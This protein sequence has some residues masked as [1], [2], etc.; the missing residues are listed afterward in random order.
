[1]PVVRPSL[2]DPKRLLCRG[3]VLGFVRLRPRP[4]QH[5]QRRSLRQAAGPRRRAAVELEHVL[6]RDSACP[7]GG[8]WNSFGQHFLQCRGVFVQEVPVGLPERGQ[9]L[10]LDALTRV[11]LPNQPAASKA[12]ALIGAQQ[13][14]GR[15]PLLVAFKRREDDR[16][17][18]GDQ[19]SFA[20][21]RFHVCHDRAQFGGPRTRQFAQR[22]LGCAVGALVLPVYGF[23]D[24]PA[25]LEALQGRGDGHTLSARGRADEHCG[26]HDP[27]RQRTKRL[28]GHPADARLVFPRFRSKPCRAFGGSKR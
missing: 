21:H 27:E 2:E 3:Q 24:R 12:H 8:Q 20:C 19:L 16:Q 28:G 7:L 6:P 17:A 18:R 10:D 25:A 1:M 11:V 4:C 13:A 22:T 14:F 23:G 26:R 9:P 5:L 15:P